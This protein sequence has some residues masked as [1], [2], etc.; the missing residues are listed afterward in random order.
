M[1]EQRPRLGQD[2]PSLTQTRIIQ[3]VYYWTIDSFSLWPPAGLFAIQL[4]RAGRSGPIVQVRVCVSKTTH[5]HADPTTDIACVPVD[6]GAASEFSLHI[7]HYSVL[8]LYQFSDHAVLLSVSALLLV[9]SQ[10]F[11]GSG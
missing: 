4:V 8:F 5:R 1:H 6:S 10:V 7:K 3:S 2:A 11:I 9:F